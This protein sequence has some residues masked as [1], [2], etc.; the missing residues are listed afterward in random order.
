VRTTVGLVGVLLDQHG[1]L[2]PGRGSS[3]RQRVTSPTPTR[4]VIVVS[5]KPPSVRQ[6][7][8][9]DENRG[10]A[11]VS[12]VVVRGIHQMDRIQDRCDIDDVDLGDAAVQA[13]NIVRDRSISK[14]LPII[15]TSWNDS[16]ISRPALP[17][18]PSGAKRT[19]LTS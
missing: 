10:S 8:I 13:Q 6:L 16:L 4:T 7:A 19:A 14:R 18:G 12:D 3:Q 2:S 17:A 5:P 11:R 15:L 1:L 9:I